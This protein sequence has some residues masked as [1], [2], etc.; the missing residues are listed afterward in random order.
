MMGKSIKLLL[1]VCVI[2]CLHSCGKNDDPSSLKVN[3]AKIDI[4][5]PITAQML[6]YYNIR[7]DIERPLGGHYAIL[8]TEEDIEDLL[9][10]SPVEAH[11]KIIGKCKTEGFDKLDEKEKFLDLRRIYIWHRQIELPVTFP[12]DLEFSIKYMRNAKGESTTQIE[13][14][15]YVANA[16]YSTT[17]TIDG[18]NTVFSASLDLPR[19]KFGRISPLSTPSESD[20]SKID[21]EIFPIENHEI[22]FGIIKGNLIQ[23]EN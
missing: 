15:F 23:Q 7:I 9:D 10:E 20:R 5:L 4:D 18:S 19:L 13:D 3:S 11:N 6:E 1:F 17:Y 21:Q 12:C 16:L 8:I 2:L 14:F 22:T